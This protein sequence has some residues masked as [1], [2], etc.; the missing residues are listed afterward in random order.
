MRHRIF[1]KILIK[2]GRCADY[3]GFDVTPQVLLFL[4]RDH[5]CVVCYY[6]LFDIYKVFMHF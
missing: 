5:D 1:K 6:R 2:I 3:N 4:L